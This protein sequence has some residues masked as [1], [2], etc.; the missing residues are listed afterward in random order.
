MPLVEERFDLVIPASFAETPPVSRFLD[1]LDDPGFRTE[2]ASLPGYDTS[3]S[4]HAS[5]LEAERAGP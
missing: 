4:G 3:I 2:A 1:T 5:T